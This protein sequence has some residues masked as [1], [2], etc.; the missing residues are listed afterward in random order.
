MASRS[1]LSYI[2]SKNNLD[3]L[4]GKYGDDPELWQVAGASSLIGGEL[5]DIQNNASKA[6]LQSSVLQR[7][8]REVKERGGVSIANIAQQEKLVTGAQKAHFAKAGVKL[9]GSALDVIQETVHSAT[10]ATILKQRELDY[11]ITNR[12]IERRLAAQR[13]KAATVNSLLNIGSILAQSEI[14]SNSSQASAQTAL[15]FRAEHER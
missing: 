15:D 6:N 2:T 8:Q 12:D 5:V 14:P 11:E 7:Q 3:Y 4:R 9:E 10:E 13:S 1:G